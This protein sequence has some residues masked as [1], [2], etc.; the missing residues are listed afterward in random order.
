MRLGMEGENNQVSMATGH[1]LLTVAL[2]GL[3]GST[4]Y[5]FAYF[6]YF[7]IPVSHL[8]F[9]TMDLVNSLIFTT[10]GF[11]L[12]ILLIV[13]AVAAYLH[14][15]HLIL[16]HPKYENRPIAKIFLLR[17]VE[18][19]TMLFSLAVLYRFYD[20]TVRL[21]FFAIIAV[22]VVVLI[23]LDKILD[24]L[25][26]RESRI[27]K[28]RQYT[29]LTVLFLGLFTSASLSLGFIEA[30]EDAYKNQRI[31]TI[32]YKARY[33]NVRILRALSKGVLFLDY[34]DHEVQFVSW[35]KIDYMT[36]GK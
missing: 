18:F 11:V 33:H 5:N 2:V 20:D 24:K 3:V 8:G 16:E 7:R 22:V 15:C 19:T 32:V 21:K 1:L 9:G 28:Q 35:Q 10:P 17:A 26:I 23:L 12:C 31:D 29:Y 25:F 14:D 27:A 4:C 36:Y 30:R 34:K 13:L 6:Y